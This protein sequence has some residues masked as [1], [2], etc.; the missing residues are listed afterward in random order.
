[1]P[2]AAVGNVTAKVTWSPRQRRQP[3]AVGKARVV[4]AFA[5]QRSVAVIDLQ[6]ER[7]QRRAIDSPAVAAPQVVGVEAAGRSAVPALA[8]EQLFL[9]GGVPLFP[10]VALPLEHRQRA[11][12]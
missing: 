12:I 4:G 3:G 5:V 1:S 6:R 11:V 8:G 10:V 7:C 9:Q 2:A